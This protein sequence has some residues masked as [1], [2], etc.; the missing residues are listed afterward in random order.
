[1]EGR[2]LSSRQTQHVVRDE[3]IGQP[4]NSGECSEA[5][6]GVTRES[7]DKPVIDIADRPAW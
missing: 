1:M 6:D 7:E 5:T 3:E 4:S 2:G